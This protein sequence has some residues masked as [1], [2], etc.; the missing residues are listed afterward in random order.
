[1][2]WLWVL[3]IIILAVI[4][5]VIT[6]LNNLMEPIVEIKRYADDVLEHGVLL[7]AALDGVD[8]LEETRDQ[9]AQVAA[10]VKSYGAALQQ[11]G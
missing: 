10:G 7:I 4:P 1:M 3:G 6:L 2:L 8:L 5:V 9:T 11:L